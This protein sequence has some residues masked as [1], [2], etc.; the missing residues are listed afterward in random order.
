[1][2]NFVATMIVLA[3]LALPAVS[4]PSQVAYYDS[5]DTSSFYIELPCRFDRVYLWFPHSYVEDNILVYETEG[6]PDDHEIRNFRRLNLEGP[7]N[8]KSSVWMVRFPEEIQYIL[9]SIATSRPMTFQ[10]ATG[11]GAKGDYRTI[12]V[13]TQEYGFDYMSCK[14]WEAFYN[15]FKERIEQGETQ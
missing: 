7:L 4:R 11:Q 10:I 15:G 6:K 9:D 13:E 2:K 5:R 14:K 8:E 3:A 1:M 12:K